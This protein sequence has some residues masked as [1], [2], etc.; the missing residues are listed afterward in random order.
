MCRKV[1]LEAGDNLGYGG[2]EL[3][4]GD[5]DSEDNNDLIIDNDVVKLFCLKYKDCF[6]RVVYDEGYRVKNKVIIS[7]FSVKA[8]LASHV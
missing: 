1:R 6:I 5:E 8:L 2:Q 4:V 3:E 7:Y